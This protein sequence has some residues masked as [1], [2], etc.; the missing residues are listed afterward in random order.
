MKLNVTKKQHFV[1]REYLRPWCFKKEKIWCSFNKGT[2]FISDLMGVGTQ[3]YFYRFNP[4]FSK[5]DAELARM[6]FAN[7]Q[8]RE[9]Y[10]YWVNTY[11][12]MSNS[13]KKMS[14]MD[15]K[16]DAIDA[17]EKQIEE[18]INCKLEE[19]FYPILHKLQKGDISFYC[20]QAEPG[21]ESKLNE[22]SDFLYGL[23]EVNFRTK[24][25]KNRIIKAFSSD[26][27]CNG[28]DP[29]IL[30]MLTRHQWATRIGFGILANHFN[31]FIL[32][33]NTKSLIT[34]DQPVFNSRPEI[35]DGKITNVELYCPLNP[36]NAL[37]LTLETNVK[38]EL[39]ECDRDYYNKLVRDQ[40]ETQIYSNSE[41][42]LKYVLAIE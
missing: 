42:V 12:F 3:Q 19:V 40:S 31:L 7:E 38:T 9:I 24:N 14:D 28:V 1:P 35:I 15:E 34:C 27:K 30:W 36:E 39:S 18:T 11:E 17:F 6:M 32:H 29:E 26:S 25:I 23:M 41:E 10:D 2:P 5:E 22:T 33:D 21:N 13:I 4:Y 16:K 37:L 20:T 8:N